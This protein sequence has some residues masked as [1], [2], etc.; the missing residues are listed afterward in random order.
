MPREYIAFAEMTC[1]RE[2]ISRSENCYNLDDGVAAVNGEQGV[3]I[4]SVGAE[5]GVTIIDFTP[6]ALG[7]DKFLHI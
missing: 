5:Y 2:Y 1:F 4:N 6:H 7:E 3:V